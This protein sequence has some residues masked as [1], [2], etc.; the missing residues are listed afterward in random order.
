MQKGEVVYIGKTNDLRERIATHRR[1][2]KFDD[3][4]YLPVTAEAIDQ[5]KKHLIRYFDLN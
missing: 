5:V 1:V 3:V 2:K 4:L